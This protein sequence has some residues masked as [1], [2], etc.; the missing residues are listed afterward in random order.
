MPV[1]EQTLEDIQP[2][3]DVILQSSLSFTAGRAT[4]GMEMLPMGSVN[5]GYE[6]GDITH[7]PVAVQN[8]YSDGKYDVLTSNYGYNYRVLTYINDLIHVFCF[9]VLF[10]I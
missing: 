10:V 9:A 3:D 4:R 6:G 7:G 2:M 1:K 8:R 5:P